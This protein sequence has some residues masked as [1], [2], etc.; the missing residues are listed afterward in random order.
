AWDEDRDWPRPGT[1]R[2]LRHEFRYRLARLH[3]RRPRPRQ[4]PAR[5]WAVRCD[6]RGEHIDDRDEGYTFHCE[7]RAGAEETL[8]AYEFTCLGDLVFCPEDA[9]ADIGE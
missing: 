1:L 4:L 3:P 5:C 8:A 2:A 9:P 6:G 7:S